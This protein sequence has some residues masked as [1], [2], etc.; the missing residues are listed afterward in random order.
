MVDMT[1]ETVQYETP[2][3]VEVGNFTDVTLGNG[4]WGW[5]SDHE[6]DWLA[7]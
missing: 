7:C 4:S 1:E 2:M 3:L 6:C 5:E